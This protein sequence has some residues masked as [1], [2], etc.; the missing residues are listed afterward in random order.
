MKQEEIDK[1]AKANALIELE[2]FAATK[3]RFK[4]SCKN[5]FIRGFELAQEKNRWK[6]VFEETPPSNIELLAE[7]P[8]GVIHL[9]YWRAGYQ[10]FS[11]QVKSESSDDWKWKQI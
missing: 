3:E 6:T 2:K 4:L 11:C 8:D 5:S 1:A 7:S 10:I 9:T